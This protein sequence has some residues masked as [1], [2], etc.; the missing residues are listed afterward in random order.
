MP[1]PPRHW[2]WGGGMWSPRSL[3]SAAHFV[4]W[5]LTMSGVITPVKPVFPKPREPDPRLARLA[6]KIER[7]R[8]ARALRFR[9]PEPRE[10]LHC[11]SPPRGLI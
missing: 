7:V 5:S 9:R 11:I 1:R 3:H 2:N 10:N 8:H 4:L 6:E